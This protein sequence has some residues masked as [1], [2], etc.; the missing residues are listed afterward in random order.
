MKNFGKNIN[1]TSTKKEIS[2]KDIF[3]DLIN[4]LSDCNARSSSLVETAGI[5]LTSYEEPYWIIIENLIQ[6]KYG[7]W[8]TEIIL[9]WVY[10]RFDEEG[11]LL[12]IEL[13]NEDKGTEEKVYL[14]TSTNLWNFL[15][16]IDKN[17]K[18]D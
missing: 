5:D 1:I 3:I 10:D 17:N 11:K 6:L 8:K 14:K 18:N 7:D 4:A 15:K 9:W 13:N 16:K 2:E 12:P